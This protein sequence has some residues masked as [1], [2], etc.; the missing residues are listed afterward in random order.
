M[1]Q[2]AGAADLYRDVV[3]SGECQQ[4][5]Q[6]GPAVLGRGRV[7]RLHQTH[8]VHHQRDVREPRG[9]FSHLF[10][11]LGAV[12]IH[13]QIVHPRRVEQARDSVVSHV[14]RNPV[15]EQ[16][17][18]AD[19]AVPR[20]PVG[21]FVGRV[22]VG[23]I[24]GRDQ[25][26]PAGIFGLHLQGEARVV[27]IHGVGRDENR[28][29]HTHGVHG[30]DHLRAVGRG[31][32]CQYGSPGPARMVVLIGVDLGVDNRRLLF[33]HGLISP[34][35][36]YSAG[37]ATVLNFVGLSSRRPGLSSAKETCGVSTKGE[38]HD[39]THRNLGAGPGRGR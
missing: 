12:H 8:M 26:E 7:E 18:D 22:R 14:I 25:P 21:N 20:R 4:V 2:R 11:A 23:C 39:Q 28:A 32:A 33:C 27:A 19:R 17:A 3:V 38:A 31:R 6:V 37:G 36:D 29:V 15:G 5:R 9:D 30:G 34:N 1:R 35:W 16:Q 24:E 13:R 10:V